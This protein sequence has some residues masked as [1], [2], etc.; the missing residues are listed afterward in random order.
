MKYVTQLL[1]ILLFSVL[2]EALEAVIPLPIPAAIYGLVLLL[3][4]LSTGLLKEEKIAAAADFLIG[5]MPVLFV[6]PAVKILQYWGLIAPNLAAICSI[7]V[8]STFVV[9]ITSGLVT[10]WLQRRKGDKENG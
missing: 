10:K 2:G 6:A 4:A 8:L 7:T 1:Y 3:I 5:A 9:F